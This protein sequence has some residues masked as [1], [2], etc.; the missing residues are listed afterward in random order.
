MGPRGKSYWLCE[1]ECGG[2]AVVQKGN[3]ISGSVSSC[4]CIKRE[5]QNIIGKRFGRLTVVD[6]DHIDTFGNPYLVCECDC[7]NTVIV[8]RGNLSHGTTTS[9]GC[10]HW[11]RLRDSHT[12]HGLSNDRLYGIWRHMRSRC[13]NINDDRYYRYGARGIQVCD[14]W[15]D[16]EKFYNWAISSGYEPDLTID[17]INNDD[18]YYPDNCRWANSITQANNKNNNCLVTYNGHTHTIAEWA[19]MF[20]LK[21]DILWKRIKQNNMRDF[22]EYF[23]CIDL[24][25]TV[26]RCEMGDESVNE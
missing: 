24:N 23:G 22:E 6:F 7:G 16:F 26:V 5:R 20:E 14:D 8:R 3:L 9:C 17:R 25:Y 19:R 15:Q 21:Y 4:G 11:E 1:C 18:G 10:Y 2:K 12:T 13:E